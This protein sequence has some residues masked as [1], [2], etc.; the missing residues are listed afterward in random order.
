MNSQPIPLVKTY[1]LLIA[2]CV[3]FFTGCSK[4]GDFEIEQ[5]SYNPTSVK[6]GSV[7]TTKFKLRNNLASDLRILG[8]T[9]SCT[10]TVFDGL[11]AKLK[12]KGTTIITV[13][14]LIPEGGE[15]KSFDTNLLLLLDKPTRECPLITVSARVT[16]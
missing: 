14:S 10:C 4:H 3:S 8:A 15:N 16:H 2:I 1:S 12:P 7:L 5:V 9:T 13:Q 6:A 11:P